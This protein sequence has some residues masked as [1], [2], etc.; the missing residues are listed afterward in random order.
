MTENPNPYTFLERVGEGGMGEVFL[1]RDTR[2]DRDVAVKVLPA[3]VSQD[4]ERD[5]RFRREAKVLASLNHPNIAAIYSV[6]TLDGRTSLIMEYVPGPTLHE[7]IAGNPL[8]FGEAL[9]IARQIA[10]ALEEAHGKDIVHRDLKPANIK[11]DPA[12]RVK[13]LDF[14]LAKVLSG[15]SGSPDGES[16]TGTTLP[17]GRGSFLETQA[18]LVMGTPSYMS[19]EQMR[20]EPVDGRTDL[21]ALGC[22]LFEMLTGRTAFPGRSYAE[23]VAAVLAKEPSWDAL[24][25]DTPEGVRRLLVSCLAKDAGARVSRARDVEDEIRRAEAPAG[26]MAAADASMPRLSQLTYSEA[27]EESP[28]WS[29]DGRELLFTRQVGAVRKLFRLRLESGESFPV[30][31]GGHDDL[32]PAWHPARD[33][34]LFVRGR[35]PGR[36]LQ[37]GDVFGIFGAAENEGDV[38][39]MDLETGAE[40]LL[41]EMGFNPAYSPDGERIA[42]DASWAGPRRIWIVD[43]HGRNPQQVTTDTSE[44][45]DHVRPRWSPDGSRIVFQNIERT[46][47]DI[48]S[49]DLRTREMHWVSRDLVIDVHP[50]W[51]PSG[52]YVYFTSYRSGGMNLWRVAVD[53]QGAPRGPLRQIT[54]GAGQDV[55]ACLS[56]DGKRL[57][58]CILLQNSAIWRL[59]VSPETGHVAGEP[60]AVVSSTRED[61]R[62]AWSAGDDAIA[63]NSNRTGDMNLWLYRFA[64]RSLTQLTHG[65]GGDYQPSWSP[66]GRSLVFFSSRNGNPGIW[67]LDLESREI[68]CLSPPEQVEVNPF[69]S[70]D[71]SRIA[72]QSD[73]D[74]RLEVWVMNADGSRPRQVTRVGAMGHFLRWSRD[75]EWITFRSQDKDQLVHRVRAEGG[76]PEALPGVKGGS[77]LSLNPGE[78][79]IMDVIAHQVLWVSPVAGGEAVAGGETEAVYRFENPDVRIDYPVWSHGGDWILF[80]RFSP[81]GGDIWMMENF[82]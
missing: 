35:T 80:D 57:A 46:Q 5:R 44:A 71:G 39:E 65:R 69:F 77:H 43:R 70:P 11:I 38:W 17:A 63:F 50:A 72:Y 54:T 3:V 27:I 19:P 55:E 56:P 28:T 7:R 76:E 22:V 78:S 62:G 12:G 60:K 16:P 41:I 47:F 61:S 34:V 49:V 74:G 1:A 6:E 29:P 8:P 32:Q 2:L 82:E 58:F 9:R 31:T 14:G 68:A 79:R 42:V 52:E 48:R 59:P 51:S 75:G 67:R 13:V 30:T 81:R 66:D 36:R 15:A 18:G 23:I 33:R 73:R 37:P 26:D 20:G 40:R 21:W 25:G 24:P 64:D 53:E 4:P 10:E 45:V